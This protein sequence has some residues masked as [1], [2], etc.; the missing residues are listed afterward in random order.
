MNSKGVTFTIIATLL[1]SILLFSIVLHNNLKERTSSEKSIARIE[2]VNSFY[3]SLTNHYI[4]DAIKISA[5]K[6]LLSMINYTGNNKGYLGNTKNNVLSNFSSLISNGSFDN[7]ESYP[8]MY[9]KVDNQNVAYDLPSLMNELSLIPLYELGIYVY[10]VINNEKSTFDSEE[11]KSYVKNSLIINDVAN[12]DPFFITIKLPLTIV[13][14]DSNRNLN[15]S[16]TKDFSAILNISNYE[17]PLTLHFT[18][19]NLKMNRYQ[20]NAGDSNFPDNLNPLLFF[21]VSSTNDLAQTYLQRFSADKT[22]GK[23]GIERWDPGF[24]VNQLDV[25]FM[26]VAFKN[27]GNQAWLCKEPYYVDINRVNYCS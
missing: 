24:G 12:N 20:Y 23:I 27:F 16:T 26:S 11:F 2:T 3:Y 22:L 19:T 25:D 8:L 1:V 17:D 9:K 4:N 21:K 10:P 15:F 7:S 18:T 14:E 13:V 5:D 6:A